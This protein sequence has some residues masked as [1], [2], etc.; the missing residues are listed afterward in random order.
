MFN[1]GIY[2]YC[3]KPTDPSTVNPPVLPTEDVPKTAKYFY[4]IFNIRLI[5][6]A[7]YGK[8]EQE[9]LILFD[10]EKI[11]RAAL[12]RLLVCSINVCLKKLTLKSVI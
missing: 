3:Q 7:I 8:D 10:P 1:L 4:V 5:D 2:H 6:Y 9:R 11:Y 12:M